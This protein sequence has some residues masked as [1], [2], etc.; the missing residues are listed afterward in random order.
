MVVMN[1]ALFVYRIPNSSIIQAFQGNAVPGIHP[2]FVISP[3]LCQKQ[4]F[5]SIVNPERISLDDVD[6]MLH[7]FIDLHSSPDIPD[8]STSP[9]NYF[10]EVSSIIDELKGDQHRK[11]IACRQ[12]VI[13]GKLKVKDTFLSLCEN[14]P[15]AF[16][17]L[18]Y[19][20]ASGAW[21][22]ASPELLLEARDNT[23][24]TYALAGTRPSGSLSEWDNKNIL[25]HK[26][27]ADYLCN[28]F[29]EFG[30]QPQSTP[31]S[32]RKAG[33]VEHL[34]KKI[35]SPIDVSEASF[36]LTDFLEQLSPTPALCGMPKQESL[37]RIQRLESFDRQY[38]GGFCGIYKND[39]D[40]KFY[41]ILRSLTFNKTLSC[42]YAGGGITCHSDPHSE[43]TET[44]NKASGIL[45]SLH[46]KTSSHKI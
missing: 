26:I 21:I 37:E 46:L 45:S 44:A 40:L 1:C 20:P 28:L 12:I 13:P 38:Y 30:L 22:G 10:N 29:R 19:T 27:V 4:N 5:I 41:V 32:T 2:G 14:Y 18:F 11:T 24:Y 39:R 9:D 43:W 35:W 25:E 3:F 33:N 16:V 42:L 15:S 6:S 7:N 17:F 31:L 34:F 36:P 8:Q 23:L